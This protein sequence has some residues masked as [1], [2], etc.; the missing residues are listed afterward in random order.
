M[1]RL[2][3]LTAREIERAAEWTLPLAYFAYWTLK[4]GGCSRRWIAAL[5]AARSSVIGGVSVGAGSMDMHCAAIGRKSGMG[6]S[7]VPGREFAGDSA[8]IGRDF[9][10]GGGAICMREFRDAML[11]GLN[12]IPSEKLFSRENVGDELKV[13]SKT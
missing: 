10:A 3:L 12:C 6:R 9:C 11:T 5:F 4:L 2:L 8:A 7:S 13:K 1:F